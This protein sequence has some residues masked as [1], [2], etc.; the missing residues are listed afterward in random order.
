MTLETDLKLNPIQFCLECEEEKPLEEGECLI[1]FGAYVEFTC[2][3]CQKPPATIPPTCPD[4]VS[5]PHIIEITRTW[6]DKDGNA[7]TETKE[8][9]CYQCQTA[10]AS[11]SQGTSQI[12][13]ALNK[14]GIPADVYQ[15]G[16][17]TM[18]VYIKTGAES[19]IYANEEGF[20]FY[21]GEE[22]EGLEN[23][24]FGEDFQN[25]T[26]EEKAQKIAKEMKKHN[27]TALEV[28]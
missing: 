4:F 22:C 15:T 13:Q 14:I 7:T 26:P 5:H 9:G 17:F 23:V 8:G 20:S 1:R 12:A 16:G 21:C 28:N 11:E 3:E 25:Q 19:Y 2:Y 18:C 10:S 6:K 24:F 27:L